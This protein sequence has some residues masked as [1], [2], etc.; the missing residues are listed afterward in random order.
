M[1]RTR[2]AMVA[3]SFGYVQYGL[4]ILSGLL[5]VPLT[6]HYLGARTYGLWLATGELLGYAALVDLGVL[7]VLPWMLAEADGR[8]DRAAMRALLSNGVAVGFVVA[9]GYGIVAVALWSVLPMAL[10]LPDADRHLLVGPLAVL[11]ATTMVAY[12]L[13]VFSALIAGMQDV[14]YNG[15]IGVAQVATSLTVACAMLAKGYGVYALAVAAA[16][17]GALPS[18]ACAARAIVLAP[19]LMRHWPMPA[20]NGV[21]LL[22]INGVGGWLGAFG[23]QLVAA[24]NSLVIATVGRPEWVPIYACTARLSAMVTQVAWLIPDAGLIGLAQLHGE[25]HSVDRVRRVIQMMLHL[26]LL[27]AGAAAC[28]VLVFNPAFAVRWVGPEFFGGLP[29]HLLL[30]AGIVVSSLAHGLLAAGSV[31]G[32]RL[33]IGALTLANGFVQVA[34]ALVLT[35]LWGLPGIAA[36]SL[37]TGLLIALPG[38]TALLEPATALTI[39]SVLFEVAAPWLR[40]AAPLLAVAVLGAL[41]STTLDVWGAAVC[42]AALGAL[43]VWWMRSLFGNL[44]LDPRLTRWLVSLRLVP[45]APAI[46]QLE[47][48]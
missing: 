2:K 3:A 16:A 30:A 14:R 11:V 18:V 43:Y 38:A 20:R 47:Q 29:L 36:A 32:N 4:A 23:W 15:V 28:C 39:R 7:G 33:R 22:L 10:R 26:H 1:S 8:R 31:V 42:A 37:L 17:S 5:L 12:P 19:D 9:L 27:L 35:R 21:R 45:E 13:R 46:P 34:C 25:R 24:S 40:R 41:A 6:L 48:S 44:P